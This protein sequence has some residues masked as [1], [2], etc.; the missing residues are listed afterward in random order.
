MSLNITDIIR[1]LNGLFQSVM[2]NVVSLGDDSHLDTELKPIK[3]GEK[4][5]PL[6]MSD[7][8]V[9][10]SGTLK[11]KDEEVVSQGN[12]ITNDIDALICDTMTIDS[13][14]AITL[15]SR[16]GAFIASQDGAEFSRN[17]DA[18]AGM[19]LGY[20]RLEGDVAG[21]G[22]TESFEIQNSL[23]VEDATHH[24]LFKTPPSEKVEIEGTCL[25]NISS[26]DTRISVGLSD[27]ST[28]NKVGEQFEYDN[29]GI[30]F[31][32]DEVDDHVI[33]FKFVLEAAQL[34]A[35]GSWNTFYIG[36]STSGS[37]KTAYLNY[38][39][40]LPHNLAYHPFII[41]ATAL[42]SAI[43]DGI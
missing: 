20:T 4:I 3:I 31:T 42:P 14:G 1:Q 37:T 38:G 24:I 26:T 32:D 21:G 16:S 5:T 23:T 39:L 13:E 33:T 2:K 19:I 30:V 17:S 8:E 9:K 40:R 10:V 25:M 34:A 15:D 7:T 22:G 28:Y 12:G 29:V 6:E 43:N 35:V 11:Y 18:Y 27:S 36:F 41:K